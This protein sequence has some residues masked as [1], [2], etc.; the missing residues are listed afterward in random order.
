ME[1]FSMNM[2]SLSTYNMNILCDKLK[3]PDCIG[4]ECTFKQSTTKTTVKNKSL[5]LEKWRLNPHIQELTV[6]LLKSLSFFL[7]TDNLSEHILCLHLLLRAA[8]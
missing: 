4:G 6:C 8:D 1:L 5:K 3:I 7:G 2:R